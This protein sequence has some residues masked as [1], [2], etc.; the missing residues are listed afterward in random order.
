MTYETNSL[1]EAS[2]LSTEGYKLVETHWRNGRLWYAFQADAA[3]GASRY[4]YNPD[5]R[6][7]QQLLDNFRYLRK[8]ALD[9]RD[10]Q[11]SA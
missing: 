4:K 11:V 6:R 1:Y 10:R 9:E 3:E 7:A 2:Y 5:G 8:I